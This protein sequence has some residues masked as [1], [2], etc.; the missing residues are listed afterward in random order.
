MER[1]ITKMHQCRTA[2]TIHLKHGTQ[3]LDLATGAYSKTWMTMKSLPRLKCIQI[4]QLPLPVVASTLRIIQFNRN[5]VNQSPRR[6]RRMSQIHRPNPL[7]KSGRHNQ[8]SQL[9]KVK[10]KQ[11]IDD[12]IDVLIPNYESSAVALAGRIAFQCQSYIL[13]KYL[14]PTVSYPAMARSRVK[15]L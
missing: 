12:W 14:V 1:K 13:A 9:R 7:F 10:L 5:Q 11:K 3:I 6:S 4:N 8:Q 15:C 2:T